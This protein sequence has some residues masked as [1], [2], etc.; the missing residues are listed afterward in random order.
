MEPR[1]CV[2]NT[3]TVEEVLPDGV[4]IW[5][6]VIIQDDYGN[7]MRTCCKL[8]TYDMTPPE[9]IS[10]SIEVS[11]QY[12]SFAFNAVVSNKLQY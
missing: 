2:A 6:T 11:S 7:V 1:E 5:F 3:F 4:P 9:G 10:A 8:D 12:H